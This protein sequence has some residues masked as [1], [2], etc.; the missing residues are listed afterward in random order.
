MGNGR[1]ANHGG[2]PDRLTLA[3]VPSRLAWAPQAAARGVLWGKEPSVVQA[4]L[5]RAR[6]QQAPLSPHR[7]PWS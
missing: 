5:V 3:L 4:S 7:E 2:L 1:C 6:Q